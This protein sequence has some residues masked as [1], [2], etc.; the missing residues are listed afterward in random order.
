[1]S[2]GY[3]NQL[4]EIIMPEYGRNIQNM[5]EYCKGLTDR[6]ERSRCAHEIVRAMA[7]LVPE[8][9]QGIGRETIYWD[10][11]AIIADFE[12]DVD[13]P[14][15]TITR[16]KIDLKADKPEYPGA[17]IK[18]R[19][20]GRF[21]EGMIQKV[22]AMELGPERAAAEYFI[23]LQ[24]KRDYMTW[25]QGNVEDLKIFK[26]LF[27]LSDGQIL[28]TPENCKLNIN[29][30]TIDRPGKLQKPLNSKKSKKR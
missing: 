11:L 3:N 12:L 6:D 17:Q 2:I 9:E 7:A 10:H 19:Y 4:P 20:Y 8:K 13:Y 24:M 25:N 27:E 15:G 18:Y 16:E 26:D 1:M 28:L 5:V 14:E 29:P 23:A 22:C 30:N 21:I